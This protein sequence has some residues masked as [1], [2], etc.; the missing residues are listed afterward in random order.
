MIKYPYLD[1][2]AMIGITAP[3]SGVQVEF[4]EMFKLA[5]SRLEMKGFNI[6][7]GDTV[8]TQNKAKSSSAKKRAVEF[9]EMMQNKDI[10]IIIPPWGGELLIEMLEFVDF[11]NISE[12]W[13]LGYSDISVL[14]L[15]TTLKT[16]IATAHGTNLIDLRGEYSDDT[17][18]MWQN[19]LS[20]KTGGSILQQSSAKYQRDW[21]TNPSLCI[22]NLTEQTYWKTVSNSNEKIQGRLLGGCIDVIRHLIGTPFGDVQGFR[23]QFLNGESVIWY[24]ENCELTTVDLRR[25]LVQMKF[26][27]WFKQCS[28]IMFGRSPAN[29]PVEHYTV[30]DVYKDLSDELQIPVIYDIDCG[31]LPPQITF[32]NGAYAEV[33]ID[34]GKGTILQQFN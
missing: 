15:A 3:S 27:G 28:G 11:E 29:L 8:L 2:G 5:C 12:K 4:H 26:A 31:H 1:E 13:I 22:F 17:T 21:P 19:V 18:A 6:I 10:D 34:D 16:G 30:E 14:L 25:S 9:N 33:K 24:L 32:I 7:C 20:T 23:K